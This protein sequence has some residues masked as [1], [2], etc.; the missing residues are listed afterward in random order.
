MPAV[1]LSVLLFVL[2]T[3]E[4]NAEPNAE[5][6]VATIG[7]GSCIAQDQPIPTLAAALAAQPDLFVLTGDNV[8]ADSDD[9][10]EIAA[11]YRT[12][13]ARP[14][15]ARLRATVPL[16]AT[17]DDHDYGRND[18]GVEFPAKAASERVFLDF[19]DV[20]AGDPRRQRPGVYHAGTFGR[21]DRRVQLVLLD[22]RSFRDP[23]KLRLEPPEPRSV[24]RPGPYAVRTDAATVLGEAQWAWLDETLRQPAALRIVVSSIQV[25][26]NEHRY[27][28]WGLFEAERS[29]LLDR[30]A[31]V[32]GPVLIVSGDRHMA[33]IS[34]DAD[35]GLWELTSSSLNKPSRW[36]NERN[37]FRVGSKYHGANFGL[38]R[39]DWDTGTMS[40]VVC[41]ERGAEVLR[42]DV[43]LGAK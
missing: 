10:E 32:D 28:K 5:P 36:R 31:A 18:A 9:A 14:E 7:F 34:H 23:L 43:P 15:F 21:G 11:C 42:A 33:E 16:A 39:L 4:P 26:P 40:L 24:G 2:L 20:P 3:A 17:W 19:F 35:R 38:V 1:L 37:E 6:E 8:Y 13:A 30:L 22:T 41:D 12:L 29:R 27:E 25:L